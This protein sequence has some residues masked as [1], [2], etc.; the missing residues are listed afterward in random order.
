MAY[1]LF[2]EDDETLRTGLE[3]ALSSEGYETCGCKDGNEAL[4]A[5]AQRRPDLLILDVMMPGKSGFDVCVEVRRS[6]PTVPIIF[7]TAKTSEAD[8]VIGLGLGADDFIP[9]PFRIRELLARVSAALRRGQLAA[10]TA[11][12]DVFTIGSARIDARRFLVSTGEPPDQPLTVRELGLLKEFAAHPGEVLSRDTL[13]DEVWGMDY[14]GG[15]RTLDQH[16]V[17]VRRKLGKSGD[18]IETIRGVG[19]RLRA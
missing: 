9:K 12:S 2:A 16:I 10:T 14:A 15:T 1:V 13:L 7:L 11:P 6:D 3:A 5:F 19:Y 4:S 8:V 17:Q 18:L